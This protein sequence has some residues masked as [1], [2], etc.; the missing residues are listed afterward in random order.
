MA[1]ASV[2][3]SKPQRREKAIQRA[4]VTVTD[5]TWGANFKG[6]KAALIAAGVAKPEHFR[7]VTFSRDGD[8]FW[9]PHDWSER[10]DRF[11]IQR[12]DA[13]VIKCDDGYQV[14][15]EY[16]KGEGADLD[17]R[18]RNAGAIAVLDMLYQRLRAI[19]L[20]VPPPLLSQE[21]GIPARVLKIYRPEYYERKQLEAQ[22]AALEVRE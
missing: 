18:T 4:G 12:R 15:V 3:K 2:A 10:A 9:L 6:T 11:Q 22:R 19:M 8:L 21:L 16:A 14:F 7:G 5:Y 20:E 13:R 1:K 17:V